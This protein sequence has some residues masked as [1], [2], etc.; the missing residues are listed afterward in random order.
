MSLGKVVLALACNSVAAI[1][2]EHIHNSIEL[3][4]R[5]YSMDLKNL[6]LSVS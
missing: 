1:Q 6:I 3:V 2:R 4:S 5:N